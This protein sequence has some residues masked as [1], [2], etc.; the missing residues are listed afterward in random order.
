MLRVLNCPESYSEPEAVYAQAK[1]R[2]MNFVTI[3]DHDTTDGVQKLIAHKDV[4]VGEELSCKF[5]E[6][7]CAMHVLVWGLKK[8]DHEELQGRATDIYRVAEYIEDRQLAH[9]VAH[10]L[11]RQN[12][13]LEK[14]HLERLMLLFKGFECLNGAHS[15]LHREAFEPLLDRLDE[16][17]ITR[18]KEKHRLKARW[19]QP[20]IKS[21]TAGSDDHGLLNVGK[22]WTEFPPQAS[23]VE[24]VLECLKTAQCRPAGETGSALKLA[25]TLYSVALRYYGRHLLKPGTKLDGAGGM[26]QA[27]VGERPRPTLKSTLAS[28]W[29]FRRR[30]K[31][32][33]AAPT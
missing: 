20:W 31:I 21:R 3:T 6:D 11:Y 4:I 33:R 14:W 2:G 5:P 24:A 25:H 10:P 16:D 27:I 9:A 12:E 19:P 22:T 1:A 30:K 17:E 26:L 18:L 8:N 29:P 32:A 13:K 23:T 15:P 28:L 7:G